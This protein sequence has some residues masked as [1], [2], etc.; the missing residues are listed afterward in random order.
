MTTIKTPTPIPV[1]NISPTMPQLDKV[2]NAIMNSNVD[3]TRNAVP[4]ADESLFI[5]LLFILLHNYLCLCKVSVI[6]PSNNYIFSKLTYII[7]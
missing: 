2:V 4:S 7:H 3:V 6:Q 1:L 5:V